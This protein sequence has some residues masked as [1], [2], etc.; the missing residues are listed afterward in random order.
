MRKAYFVA[1]AALGV[2]ILIL[3]PAM[4]NPP[5]PVEKRNIPEQDFFNP[6]TD[7]GMF[8]PR[9]RANLPAGLPAWF[10]QLDTNEDGQISLHE[11]RAGGKNLDEFRTFDRTTTASSRRKKFFGS[12]KS[13]SS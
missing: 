4:T 2:S 7:P 5:P 12:R 1:F 6:G 13:R 9:F 3:Y 11:W 10:D 8:E